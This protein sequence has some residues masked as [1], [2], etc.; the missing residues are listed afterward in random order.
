MENGDAW[1]GVSK[2]TL[3]LGILKMGIV[4]GGG[5]LFN[6]VAAWC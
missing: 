6:R 4:Q 2:I 5:S 1:Y 3:P